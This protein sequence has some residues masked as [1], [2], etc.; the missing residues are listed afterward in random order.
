MDN[1]G[2]FYTLIIVV[3]LFMIFS[4][5]LFYFK[6]SQPKM[7]D[8]ITN[9]QTDELHFFVESIKKDFARG[10]II[11]GQRASSF[12][13][14]E[15]ISTGAIPGQCPTINFGT[16]VQAVLAELIYCG[17]FQGS[18]DESSVVMANYTVLNW[19]QR[20][21]EFGDTI[22]YLVD[23]NVTGIEV[24]PLGAFKFAVRG[25]MELSA[26]DKNNI[27]FFEGEFTSLAIVPIT[28][29]HDP[30]MLFQTGRYEALRNFTPCNVL[31]PVDG[32]VINDWINDE[33]YF[34][35]NET[36][37][38]SSFFDRLDGNLN[39]SD[40]Y[41][42]QA[43]NLSE[44]LDNLNIAVI[45]LE[46]LLNLDRFYD[47]YGI[48]VNVENTWVDYLY[49]Q[50]VKG[51]CKVD[52]VTDHRDFHIDPEHA[53][54]YNITG[55]NCDVRI[56]NTSTDDVFDPGYMEVPVGSTIRWWSDD[57]SG[58]SHTLWNDSTILGQVSEGNDVV[59]QFNSP[60]LYNFSCSTH[61]GIGIEGQVR[62]S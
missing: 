26:R 1:R 52:G 22:G 33:C 2:Y 13:I 29:Q 57:E 30:S 61:P 8:I 7:T 9:M 20:I 27:S 43:K 12:L 40:R 42:Q 5:T 21:I 53:L 45:G 46:T 10:M 38:A 36:Y 44:E 48:S 16:G 59:Y 35:S 4:I 49:W 24:L 62:V 55:L 18:Y 56:S 3:M 28:M 50:D 6:V 17:S 54:K 58:N 14:N 47:E 51:V 31:Y 11:S 15:D 60:G 34:T 37:N 32:D 23:L 25:Y 39:L 19:T 41:L